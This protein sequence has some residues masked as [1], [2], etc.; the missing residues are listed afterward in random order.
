MLNAIM[1]TDKQIKKYGYM[2]ENI[3][4]N[5]GVINFSD[6]G[7]EKAC[8][9]LRKTSATKF[10]VDNGGFTANV[11]RKKDTLVFFSVPYDK[12]W[13]ATV[14]GKPCE[15]EKVNAGFMAVKVEKGKSVIRF[16]YETPYLLT[17]IKITFVSA[18]VLLL[19]ILG[20]IIYSKKRNVSVEYP[21]AD[22]LIDMWT[23]QENNEAEEEY[24]EFPVKKSILD[25]IPQIEPP[26]DTGFKGGFIINT[27]IDDK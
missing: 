10:K 4:E 8:D 22:Y 9:D 26:A 27:D 6:Q 19:Y 21:E 11:T 7:I 25:D 23:N 14:N 24:L 13:S 17:G 2:F 16:D 5:M 3:E 12:G 18:V 20:F 1:L 15:I